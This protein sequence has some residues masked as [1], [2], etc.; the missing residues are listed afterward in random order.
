MGCRGD[1]CRLPFFFF[2]VRGRE[3]TYMSLASNINMKDLWYPL[4]IVCVCVC[5]HANGFLCTDMDGN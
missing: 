1:I 3:S 5:V 2:L 4:F